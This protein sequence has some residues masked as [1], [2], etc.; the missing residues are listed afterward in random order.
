MAGS[1]IRKSNLKQIAG[2]PGLYTFIDVSRDPRK[3]KALLNKVIRDAAML[4]SQP[5]LATGFDRES[6]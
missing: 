1:K 5:L 4:R 6:K 3:E 2:H